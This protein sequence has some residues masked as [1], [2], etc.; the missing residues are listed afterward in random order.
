MGNT[1]DNDTDPGNG[2]VAQANTH[3]TYTLTLSG[4]TQDTSNY[5]WSDVCT[6]D[7]ALT[8][9]GTIRTFNVLR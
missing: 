3:N 4:G 5:S 9:S 1:S 6:A 7:Q 8:A 2:L